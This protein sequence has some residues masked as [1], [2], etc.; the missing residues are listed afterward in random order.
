M[1][2]GELITITDPLAKDISEFFRREPGLRQYFEL[3]E[4]A[5]KEFS[6]RSLPPPPPPVADADA[7]LLMVV[8][9]CRKNGGSGRASGSG[10]RRRPAPT[11]APLEPREHLSQVPHVIL[12]GDATI[13]SPSRCGPATSSPC[14]ATTYEGL[15]RRSSSRRRASAAS[16]GSR[17]SRTLKID[18]HD[19]AVDADAFGRLHA[20]ILK[21][22][23]QWD[24]VGQRVIRSYAGNRRWH[25][26]KVSRDSSWHERPYVGPYLPW[27]DGAAS[28]VLSAR[29]MDVLIAAFPVVDAPPMLTILRK[30]EMYE[31]IMVAKILHSA[32][33]EPREQDYGANWTPE[34]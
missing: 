20:H 12:V 8:I 4:H 11:D 32:E 28:Y 29:S 31:D 24:F 2:G 19:A 18:D 25:F 33:I 3:S 30:T 13:R 9:S 34:P 26:D 22:A 27:A 5:S 17:G 7:K 6:D 1:E 14:A 23:A 10:S 15:P 16:T 21:P